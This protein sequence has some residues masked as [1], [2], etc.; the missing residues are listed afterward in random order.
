MKI[1]TGFVSNSSSS[2][3]MCE[4]TGEEHIGYDA[5]LYDFE[6]VSCKNGHTFSEEYVIGGFPITPLDEDLENKNFDPN[7]RYEMPVKYCP[8]CQMK[9][10]TKDMMYSYCIAVFGGEENVSKSIKNMFKTYD[11]YI[12]FINV[13]NNN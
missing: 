13:R 3:F 9:A 4:I 6:L 8:I 12:N 1:R 7:E 2:S 11:E 10:I 5:D